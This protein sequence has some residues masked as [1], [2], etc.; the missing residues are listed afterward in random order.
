M[1]LQLLFEL[2]KGDVRRIGLCGCSNLPAHR[3]ELPHKSRIAMPCLRRS[4]LLNSVIAPQ[5]THAPERWDATFGAYSC[6]GEDE[7]AVSRGNGEHRGS[8]QRWAVARVM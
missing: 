3:V 8:A 1:P 6:S 5:P 4:D 2:G 7:H